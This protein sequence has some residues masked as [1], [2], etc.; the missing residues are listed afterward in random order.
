[1]AP[2][3]AG[4]T[5]ETVSA[6]AHGRNPKEAVGTVKKQRKGT[7]PPPVSLPAERYA[8]AP[9]TPGPKT[10]ADDAID[11]FEST[12]R[13][14]KRI[15]VYELK[16][17]EDGGPNRERSYTRLPPA[18]I[19]YV[20]RVTIDAGSPASRNGVFMTNFPLDGGQFDRN[21]FVE[22]KLPTDFSKPIKI[23]LPISHAGAF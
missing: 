17:E 3:A 16:L 23:D 15:N 5:E 21:R 14:T 8:D 2:A 13:G 18:Y 20:L 12:E 4:K 10:P 19:P 6:V 1:M 22:R 7:I 11:F 9:K